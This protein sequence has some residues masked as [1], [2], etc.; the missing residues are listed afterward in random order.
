MSER[1]QLRAG[2]VKPRK[3]AVKFRGQKM[4][5]EVENQIREGDTNPSKW[6][7]LQVRGLNIGQEESNP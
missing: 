5:R 1:S 7:Q 4:S 2:K 3:Q 6:R